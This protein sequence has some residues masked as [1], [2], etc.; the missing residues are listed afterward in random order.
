MFSSFFRPFRKPDDSM[1]STGL[2]ACG[3][4]A[5]YA[6]LQHLHFALQ[7]L[8]TPMSITRIGHVTSTTLELNT[9]NAPSRNVRPINATSMP[10]AQWHGQP[11]L[12]SGVCDVS[13]IDSSPRDDG[14]AIL[15]PS[16]P[17]RYRHAS[18][19]ARRIVA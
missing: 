1:V 3:H 6:D 10:V 15:L 18:H 16:L 17:S 19:L 13:M 2:R 12:P 11:H 9:L 5:A 4:L 8:F 7:T 14:S